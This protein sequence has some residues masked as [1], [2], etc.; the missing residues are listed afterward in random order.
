[1]KGYEEELYNDDKKPVVIKP[2]LSK[3]F[4]REGGTTPER[5]LQGK[6]N[7]GVSVGLKIP[8]PIFNRAPSPVNE[9]VT[10]ETPL[11]T[12]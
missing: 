2:S 1:M 8:M 10:L 6:K 5:L 11:M 4:V 9:V 7:S 12:P 3:Q